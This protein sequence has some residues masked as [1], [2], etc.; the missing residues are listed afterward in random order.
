MST[1]VVEAYN[2]CGIY[3]YITNS[4]LLIISREYL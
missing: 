4:N 3:L 2:G 1:L